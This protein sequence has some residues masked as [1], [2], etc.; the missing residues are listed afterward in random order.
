MSR[1]KVEQ[2]CLESPGVGTGSKIKGTALLGYFYWLE[3]VH[4]LGTWQTNKTV[5]NH[6]T[7]NTEINTAEEMQPIPEW[8][9]ESEF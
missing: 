4:P 3:C 6:R 9:P 7:R 8:G 1:E 2:W 5:M